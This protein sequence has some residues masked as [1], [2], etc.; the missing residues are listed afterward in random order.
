MTMSEQQYSKE[1]IGQLIDYWTAKAKSHEYRPEGQGL[2]AEALGRVY[3]D[4]IAALR[5][6]MEL[7]PTAS[8]AVQKIE[9]L[10][11]WYLDMEAQRDK[12]AQEA[13]RLAAICAR[14]SSEPKPAQEYTDAEMACKGCSGPCGQCESTPPPAPTT[15]AQDDP[16]TMAAKAVEFL[17]AQP[18][19]ELQ[20]PSFPDCHCIGTCHGPIFGSRC[21]KAEIDA[22]TSQS[23][24]PPSQSARE[25]CE[26]CER[27]EHYLCGKQ[28]WCMCKCEGAVD[29]H[30]IDLTAS[31]KPELEELLEAFEVAVVGHA[32]AL[33]QSLSIRREQALKHKEVARAAIL[34]AISSKPDIVAVDHEGS[35]VHALPA[36][37]DEG[38]SPT[39]DEFIQRVKD[40]GWTCQYDAQW[41]KITKLHAELFQA[42]L[43]SRLHPSED[44]EWIKQAKLT[45][46]KLA[47]VLQRL[48]VPSAVE[49]RDWLS[50][51]E[52]LLQPY[53]P[54]RLEFYAETD[55][56]RDVLAERKRQVSV[57]GWT[58]EHDAEHEGGALASA[59]ACYSHLAQW[60]L[61]ERKRGDTPPELGTDNI[62][63]ALW[64]FD[65]EWWKPKDA[66]RNL[67]RAAALILADIERIDR[68]ARVTVLEDGK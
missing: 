47:S 44:E 60:Q 3:A 67:V 19:K 45:L 17:C 31:A 30:D 49:W 46:D 12:Y 65:E 11:R 51:A 38:Q 63:D 58:P 2:A 6:T 28:S 26:A 52:R 15:Q 16:K 24:P 53:D 64:P 39:A 35:P 10:Q 8:E 37:P 1:R 27:G 68:V 54:S 29:A 14:V 42:P 21:R 23:A 57:E 34:A 40:A 41:T 25:L 13:A 61:R 22:A 7:T 59:A 56:A 32:R 36:K 4:T 18:R 20:H 50:N 62:I 55:A 5:A 9:R 43:P 66:R 33:R 48:K